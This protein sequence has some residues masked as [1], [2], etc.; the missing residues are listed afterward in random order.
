MSIAPYLR[1]IGRGPKGSRDLDREQARDLMGRLLDGRISDLETGAF[2]LAMRFKG[3]TPEELAG[4]LDAVLPRMAPLDA[5]SRPVVLPSY[6][7]ARSRPNLTP[8]LALLLARHGVP[9]LVHGQAD[10]PARVSSQAVFAALGVAPA[11]DAAGARA[12]WAAG[13]PACM[14]LDALHPSLGRLLGLRSILGVRNSGHTLA[15]LLPAAPGALRVVHHTHP[16]YAVSLAALLELTRGDALLMRGCEGEPV[17]N[18]G[19]RPA[20]R[21]FVGGVERQDLSLPAGE[22]EPARADSTGAID[23]AATAR[24]IRAMLSGDAPVP[25]PILRQCEALLALRAALD[26]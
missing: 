26:A 17:A 14:P 2:V 22:P 11:V 15:K 20:L 10:D 8:L 5:P 1:E 18:P 25:E 24:A 9:V 6:S 19:R 23:P 21:A 4:F 12:R 3:E 16:E 13:E 7:G